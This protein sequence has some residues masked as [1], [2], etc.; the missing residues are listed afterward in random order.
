MK[1]LRSLTVALILLFATPAM[2][3]VIKGKIAALDPENDLITVRSEVMGLAGPEEK[4]LAFRLDDKTLLKVCWNGV[5]DEGKAR[6]G[7][8]RLMDFN[9]FEAEDLSVIGKEVELLYTGGE[10]DRIE[11]ITIYTPMPAYHFN[12]VDF[13]SPF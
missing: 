4:E 3:E 1:G 7:L 2:A 9:Y 11:I 10:I 8:S 6:V 5:C 12:P 13:V